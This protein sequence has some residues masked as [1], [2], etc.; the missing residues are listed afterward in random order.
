LRTEGV[1]GVGPEQLQLKAVLGKGSFG[2]VYLVQHKRSGQIFAMKVLRKS[3]IMGRNLV[4]YAVTERNLLSY[5]RHPFIVRLYFAFQTPSCLVL[6]LE[7]CPGGSLAQYIQRESRLSENLAKLYF[8]EVCMAIEYLHERQVVYRDLKPDNVV[9]DEIGHAKLTDFGLSKEG[10]EGIAGAKSFC[11][12]VAY[13]APEILARKGHGLAVDLYGLGVL[14]YE[15]LVGSPPYYSKN[16]EKLFKNITSAVLQ[17]PPHVSAT[18]AS[19]ICALMERNPADRIGYKQTSDVRQHGWF[20]GIDFEKVLLHEVPVPNY[21]PAA[22]AEGSNKGSAGA[23]LAEKCPNPFEGRLE[24][25][26]RRISQS[27]QDVSGW[28]FGTS[29]PPVFAPS[30][31]PSRSSPS[32]QSAPRADAAF[33]LGYP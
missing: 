29:P 2:E 4:R 8:T 12:S 3:K 30:R 22:A 27:S 28:E 14:L 32:M 33:N 26:V 7:F 9:L 25:Q 24:A 10:V 1:E 15:C 19:L 20:D 17:V 13:L 5:I 11:G 31:S 23:R 16:K 21:R 6:G 18:A